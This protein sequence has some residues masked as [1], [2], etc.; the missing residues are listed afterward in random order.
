[1]A[2]RAVTPVPRRGTPKPKTAELMF[3]CIRETK[4]TFVFQEEVAEGAEPV[5]GSLYVKKS[6]AGETKPSG[7]KVSIEIV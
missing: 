1:M 3:A 7:V 6:F 5:I 4:G 2:Q